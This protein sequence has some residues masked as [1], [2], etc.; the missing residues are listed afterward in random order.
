[1]TLRL[2]PQE[3][4]DRSTS[5]L[6]AI[7]DWWERCRL[8][9]VVEVTNG[10]AFK[11][12]EFN[13]KGDG[14]PLIR[15]RDVGQP[16]SSTHY[17][18]DYEERHLVETGDLLIGMDGDFRVARWI[19]GRAL[20][21][22]RVCRLQVRNPALYCDRFLEYVLQ[23]YLDEIHKATSSVTVK[24]LSSRTVSGLPIPLPPR[25]EQERIVAVIEEHFSRLDAVES[26]LESS[27]LRSSQ[28]LECAL[29][30]AI[31]R[32]PAQESLLASFLTQKLNNGRS[33]PTAN[34]DGFPILRLTCLQSGLVNT[35]ETKLGDFSGADHEKY[36]IE[37]DD[38]LISR[39]NGSIRLVGIG[40][41]VP[42]NAPPV[43]FPDTLI[44]ARVDQKRLR[45]EFL[46]V[47]WNSKIVRRQLESQARTTAGIYKVNQTMIGRVSFPMPSPEDQDR[48]VQEL[49]RVRE[50]VAGLDAGVS[51][52]QERSKS[53]RRS[54][55]ADAFSGRL[56]P[57]EPDDEL[58][59]ALLDR[60]A[61]SR[62]PA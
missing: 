17:S 20:L 62:Q 57:Q 34:G 11:S 4:V 38:F 22:Q 40:G 58:A 51:L 59:S 5:S 13:T 6:L 49:D 36:R 60:I 26:A 30:A 45:P 3:I 39:G 8:G 24:H 53:L 25:A 16:Q 2:A 14:L 37:P 29:Q 44:R 35:N 55:L 56:V 32:Y 15:I 12:Q 42:A 46:R 31:H 7:A 48:L 18:G 50:V 52:A 21:N 47:I 33:V 41:L 9:D 19:G 23:P 1:M 54:I 28:L 61:A 27:H 10:A 43:A